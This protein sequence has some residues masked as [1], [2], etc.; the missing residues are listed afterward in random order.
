MEVKN[1]K[2]FEFLILKT[3]Y[4]HIYET[5]VN[6]NEKSIHY[7]TKGYKE[8]LDIDVINKQKNFIYNTFYIT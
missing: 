2:Y 8:L 3:S 1:N 4:N 6:D 7:Q 5:T